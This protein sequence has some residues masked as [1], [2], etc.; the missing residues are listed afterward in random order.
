[1]RTLAADTPAH[2][3]ALQI[4]RMRHMPAWQKLA[5]AGQMNRMVQTLALNGLRRRYPHAS[6]AELQRR[7]VEQRLGPQLAARV[8]GPLAGQEYLDDQRAG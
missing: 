8:Y 1:M 7:L 5:L 4:E 3:E 6:D 2:I